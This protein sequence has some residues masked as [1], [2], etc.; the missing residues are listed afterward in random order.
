[1]ARLHNELFN[2]K[3]DLIQLSI[4]SVPSKVDVSEFETANDKSETIIKFGMLK[5]L[6]SSNK[7]TLQRQ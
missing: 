2:E 1:M 4:V 6:P 7:W 3:R 5:P